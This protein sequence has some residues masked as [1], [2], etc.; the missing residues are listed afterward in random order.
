MYI[1]K[2]DGKGPQATA[3]NNISYTAL[4]KK[5]TK[6]TAERFDYIPTL[7]QRFSDELDFPAV[8]VWG[9]REILQQAYEAGLADAKQGITG[10][11]YNKPAN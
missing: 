7:E 10:V 3:T 4:N 9:L 2:H 8:S 5:L 1:P 11:G 6:I